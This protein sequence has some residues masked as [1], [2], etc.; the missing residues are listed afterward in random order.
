[1]RVRGWSVTLSTLNFELQISQMGFFCQVSLC[2]INVPRKL[3][4]FGDCLR[5]KSRKTMQYEEFRRQGCLWT[6]WTLQR[7]LSEIFLDHHIEDAVPQFVFECV[8]NFQSLVCSK[9]WYKQN[10]WVK[11]E[12]RKQL[13][14]F[15]KT[16]SCFDCQIKQPSTIS[17]IC[18]SKSPTGIFARV[19]F[20]PCCN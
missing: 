1:M 4:R 19:N 3:N 18:L 2:T 10:I 12:K 9:C 16:H 8:F 20:K 15:F 17:N 11:V 7:C 5:F 6:L 14:F 13:K